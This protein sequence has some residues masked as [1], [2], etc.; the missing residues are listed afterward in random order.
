M[1]AV[2]RTIR[3]VLCL[4]YFAALARTAYGFRLAVVDDSGS[5]SGEK[6]GVVRKQLLAV[7]R[8][9]PPTK[10]EPFGLVVFGDSAL[11]ARIFTDLPSA[12][13]AI[14]Q[15]AGDS[16]GT[17]IAAGLHQAVKDLEHLGVGKDAL[18]LLFTDGQDPNGNGIREA[19]A[20]LDALFSAR[21][22][23]GLSQTVYVKQW[24]AGGLDELVKRVRQSGSADVIDGD[25]VVGIPVTLR[26]R[27]AIERV[28]RLPD[29]RMVE[30]RWVAAVDCDMKDCNLPSVR[31]QCVSDRFSGETQSLVTV[32]VPAKARTMTVSLGAA[33]DEAGRLDVAFTAAV[34]KNPGKMPLP[35]FI[36]KPDTFEVPVSLP[37]MQIRNVITATLELSEPPSWA[38]PLGLVARYPAKLKFNVKA[39]D[40]T[41]DV[42][43][44]CSL[45][46]VPA[47]RCR[48]VEGDATF[49]L[50]GPGE[51]E[52][53]L[54]FAMPPIN[55]H[56]PR[57]DLRYSL[58]FTLEPFNVPPYL[59]F[60]PSKIEFHER[61]LPPPDSVTVPIMASVDGVTPAQWLLLPGVALTYVDLRVDL[62]G[63]VPS[64]TTLKV[65]PQEPARRVDV[66][67]P[68][69]HSG[70][71]R[72]R[73]RVAA[74]VKPA[75][76][77]TTLT[78]GL[79]AQNDGLSV[80][81]FQRTS[82]EFPVVGPDP[83]RLLHI[84]DDGQPRSTIH[85]TASDRDTTVAIVLRPIILDLDSST[86]IGSM[87]ARVRGDT[88]EG[89][90]AF[91]VIPLN[92]ATRMVLPL[93][94]R[95]NP[96]FFW[97][98]IQEI[99]LRVET[100]TGTAVVKPA[101][102]DLKVLREAR[103]RRVAFVLSVCLS[104]VGLLVLGLFTI[105][106][107]RDRESPAR[108]LDEC[109][110]SPVRTPL[111]SISPFRKTV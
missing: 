50:P 108:S 95:K 101:S 79:L 23:R 13:A 45:R 88:S 21:Q 110:D 74:H 90:I 26:P 52:L 61:D 22:K 58:R 54:A 86:S 71:N 17:D 84:D 3:V 64:G 51:Y 48:L 91:G 6:I 87:A 30:L 109:A 82:V 25:S 29:Q 10:A 103:I 102:I 70:E 72:L 55:S 9:T 73:L 76:E 75:P 19:E 7:L 60:V 105:R 78:L 62:S 5:M 4:L 100:T 85:A 68:C 12:E 57:E 104:S 43:R 106:R 63:P 80:I 92:R 38:D 53:P 37:P 28:Q 59:T 46:I 35:S 56:V 67:G 89:P 32:G 65:A 49:V 69:L 1:K 33:P 44:S 18:V 98:E 8:A 24:G 31:V 97:D 15:L 41:Q 27:V 83:V 47:A 2:A 11:P 96:S 111:S 107:L 39:G 42:D 14:A 94:K 20:K 40:P 81:E 66:V 36:L 77:K 16:G 99:P 34:D 93:P